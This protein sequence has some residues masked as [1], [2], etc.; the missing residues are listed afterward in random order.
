METL[1]YILKLVPHKRTTDPLFLTYMAAGTSG[2][3]NKIILPEYVILGCV[4][5]GLLILCGRLGPFW[6]SRWRT[7]S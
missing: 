7:T 4:G 3:H 1:I 5:A 2:R 6:R